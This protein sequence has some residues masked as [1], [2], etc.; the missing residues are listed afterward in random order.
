MSSIIFAKL[1]RMC[2]VFINIVY[3]GAGHAR[4]SREGQQALMGKLRA[5][6]VRPLPCAAIFTGFSFYCLY[7]I[8]IVIFV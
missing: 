1:A 7:D 6:H 8:L 5:A 3:V 2:F 4:P